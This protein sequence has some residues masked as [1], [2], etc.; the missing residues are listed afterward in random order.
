MQIAKWDK[1]A[2]KRDRFDTQHTR[3]QS[4]PKR[5]RQAGRLLQVGIVGIMHAHMGWLGFDDGD[6]VWVRCMLA[7][8]NSL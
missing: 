5:S 1:G 2:T 4:A 8:D 3:E 6:S 7:S